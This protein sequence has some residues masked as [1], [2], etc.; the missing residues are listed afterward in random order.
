MDV[1][2]LYKERFY[3]WVKGGSPEAALPCIYAIKYEEV[4][5]EREC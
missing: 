4:E 5:L 2:V 3:I 1:S